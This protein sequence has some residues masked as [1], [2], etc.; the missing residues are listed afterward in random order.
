MDVLGQATVRANGAAR[1]AATVMLLVA[2]A[3]RAAIPVGWMPNTTDVRNTPLVFCPG[4]AMP[5]HRDPATPAPGKTRHADRHDVCAFAGL[6]FAPGALAS[7]VADA[8]D[9]LVIARR[10]PAPV[11]PPP[12]SAQH[13]EQSARGPPRKA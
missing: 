10:D 1:L 7:G 9:V 11:R 8:P 4:G 2:L 13:R 6:G 12:V 5:M 3:L